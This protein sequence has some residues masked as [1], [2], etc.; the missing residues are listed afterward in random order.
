MYGARLLQVS[1]CGFGC[2]SPDSGAI[3]SMV[4]A[5]ASLNSTAS[6]ALSASTVDFC[7]DGCFSR[8]DVNDPFSEFAPGIGNIS[9]AHVPGRPL[10][11]N[12]RIVTFFSN[13]SVRVGQVGSE[14]VLALIFNYTT[15]GPKTASPTLVWSGA[16]CTDRQCFL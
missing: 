7:K 9:C 6:A 14:P 12:E 8:N 13:C 4:A 11:A 10:S 2:K 5:A 3:T 16:H 1:A 15:V